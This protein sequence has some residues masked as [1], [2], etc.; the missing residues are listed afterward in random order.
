MR[1]VYRALCS[2]LFSPPW[3]G[4]ARKRA[5]NRPTLSICHPALRHLDLDEEAEADAGKKAPEP[6]GSSYR[7]PQEESG[8]SVPAGGEA[9]CGQ[10]KWWTCLAFW[11]RKTPAPRAGPETPSGPKWRWPRVQL[12]RREPGQVESRLLFPASKLDLELDSGLLRAVLCSVFTMRPGKDTAHFRALPKAYTD[13]MDVMLSSLLTETPTMDK[14]EHLL[15]S[16]SDF[17][18]VGYLVAQLG[19]YITDPPDDIS[20]QTKGGIYWLYQLLLQKRGL[21][22][23]DAKEL[24]CREGLEIT[25]RLG[26][27]NMAKVGEVFGGIFSEGQGRSFLQVALLAIHDPR[28]HVSQAGL[29]L[30]FSIMG[31][32]G[33]LIGDEEKHR[34]RR[35]KDPGLYCLQ[36]ASATFTGWDALSL[37]EVK[38]GWELLDWP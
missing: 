17:P 1:C 30:A 21:N 29:V 11:R 16:S 6:V 28:L 34:Q 12:C 24:W 19:L 23:R 10:A 26:Y 25:K 31:E 20:R 13:S 4:R 27:R 5:R 36:E 32:G 3:C 8:P 9:A 37:M 18:K 38:T 22:I 35:R 7:L 14:L 33:Q 2:S 15:E